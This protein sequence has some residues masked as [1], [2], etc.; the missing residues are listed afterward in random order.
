MNV[1][2][3]LL[4]LLVLSF[5]NLLCQAQET[6]GPFYTSLAKTVMCGYQGWFTC[7]GDGANLGWTH[8]GTGSNTFQP[9]SCSIDFWPDMSEYSREECYSTEFRYPDGSQAYV[10]SSANEKTIMRHFSWMAHYGI[11]GVFLQRFIT[12]TNPGSAQLNWRDGVLR[13][14]R[15]G[16]NQYERAWAVMYDLSGLGEDQVDRVRNDW[17]H[18]VNDLKV[19]KD[20]TDRSYLHH[21]GKPVVA[22]WGIGFNDGRKYTLA[23]CSELIDYFKNDPDYGGCTVM[24]GIP[25]Y[26]REGGRDCVTDPDRLEVFAKADILSPWSVGRYGSENTSELDNYCNNVWCKDVQWCRG[27]GLDYLPVIFPGFSWHNL[28]KGQSKLNQI[29]RQGGAF[30]WHQA[31]KAIKD[32]H[33]G[34]LYIAMFDEVDEG[35]AILKCTNNPPVGDS[36]FCSYEGLPSDHYLSLTGLIGKMLRGEMPLNPQPTLK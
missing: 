24:I 36:P 16:A 25:S 6:D 32:A 23:Q 20:K 7:P 29:P 2:P 27:K 3:K 11:D 19:I 9:G 21:K 5:A 4:Y 18:L 33:A 8:W 31:Y 14:C 34:M 30:L 26:W 17:K 13:N 1:C 28:Q 15:K 10:F 12:E 35:T 22:L